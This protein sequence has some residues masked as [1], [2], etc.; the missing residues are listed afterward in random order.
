MRPVSTILIPA[1]LAGLFAAALAPASPAQQSPSLLPQQAVPVLPDTSAKEPVN[2]A[3]PN[4]NSSARP[5]LTHSDV[6]A[7]LDGF[8]PYA[9]QRGGIPGAMV[10]VVKDGNVL[11]EKGYGYADVAARKPVDPERTMFRP[12]SVSKLVTWTAVMQLVE[13]GKIDLD[14]DV[15][16]YLDYTIPSRDGKPVTVRNL[17]THTA[18]FDETARAL[19]TT[20]PK[21]MA[22]LAQGLKGA[23][24][25]LVTDPGSTPAYSNYGA[26]LAGYIVQSV[27][28]EPFDDYV[29]RHIFAPLGMQHSTF[30]QPL[31]RQF[32]D[33]MSKAYKPGSDKPQ[34]FELIGGLA[35]AGSMAASGGDM[36]RFMLAHLQGGAVGGARILRQDTA[37][38]MHTT[39]AP[40]IGPLNAML[41]GFYQTNTNGH[42]VI[43][44]AGDTQWFHSEL[45]LLLDDGVGVYVSFNSPGKE[46][47]AGVIRGTLFNQFMNRYFPGPSQDGHVAAA[48]A[49]A[50]AQLMA[51]RY[52]FT[53]RAHTTFLAGLYLLGQPEVS[54]NADDTITVSD[55][56]NLAG[57]PKKWREIAPFV[58]RNVDGTDRLAAQVENGQVVRFGYDAYPFMLFEPVPSWLSQSWLLPAWVCA[59]TALL[60]T[61]LAWPISALVRRRYG[62]AYGL[63]GRDARAHRWIRIA[64]LAV[65]AVTLTAIGTVVVIATN[66]DSAGPGMDTWIHVMRLL[67]LVVLI[68]GAAI[69]LWNAAV[70]LRSSRRWT[71]K[72]WAVVLALSC[73]V[74]LYAGVVAHLVGFSAKY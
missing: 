56:T 59:L 35:P 25:E 34:P 1:V 36:G 62:V 3:S 66:L 16:T 21:A 43:T 67:S 22:T 72:L 7:W 14:K 20:D 71:A 49:H 32:Q 17:M 47:V 11:L 27:S 64:A 53:R 26:S 33:D 41:L 29:E 13:Q 51:G 58:W 10:V 63:T 15:N 48:T 39:T 28:G 38:Q 12:G 8:M 37:Q 4:P 19:I 65:L 61:V 6:E 30:R 68:G 69:G 9:I 24:P 54:A 44:H 45:N 46:G 50:H 2:T 57:E 55:L 60:L 40:H 18:G 42:R 70:V 73:L 23:I 74:V 5:E 31:P 52:I